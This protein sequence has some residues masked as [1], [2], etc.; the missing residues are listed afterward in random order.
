MRLAFVAVLFLFA[1]AVGRGADDTPRATGT[2]DGK[3]VQFPASTVAEGVKVATDLLESC[4]SRSDGTI[5]Y[6]EAELVKARQGDHLRMVFARPIKVLGGDAKVSELVFSLPVGRGVFW[7]RT[8]EG[9]VQRH[10][11]FDFKK[12]QTFET[13]LRNARPAE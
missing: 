8:D 4:A 7:L 5:P 11:K 6:T 2:V 9:Q 3:K 10:S 1:T 13:W 12:S